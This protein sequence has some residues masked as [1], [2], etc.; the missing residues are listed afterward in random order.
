LE[1]AVELAPEIYVPLAMDDLELK[2]LWKRSDFH[3]LMQFV[4][5]NVRGLEGIDK[6]RSR[7]L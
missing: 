5:R 6:G 3:R 4:R 2:P 1:K 7:R